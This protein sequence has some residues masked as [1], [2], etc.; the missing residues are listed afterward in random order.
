M[1]LPRDFL[2]VTAPFLK[3]KSICSILED[4]PSLCS[5]LSRCFPRSSQSASH[6]ELFQMTHPLLGLLVH[7]LSPIPTPVSKSC[8]KPH[9]LLKHS[10]CL[11]L[12]NSHLA[13]WFLHFIVSKTKFSSD[14]TLASPN[15]INIA[16]SQ[17]L[18]LGIAQQIL[19]R[20]RAWC[21][22]Y[23]SGYLA[24][25]HGLYIPTACFYTVSQIINALK[26]NTNSYICNMT[27]KKEVFNSLNWGCARLL[28]A[29][30]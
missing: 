15:L 16:P 3:M 8:S 21:L 23:S 24:L 20:Q 11:S 18:S 2:G 27:Q 19:L 6:S 4:N 26:S 29:T 28:K 10:L 9:P 12:P 5:Q 30:I 17:H 7:G 14:M 25:F 22:C 1:L 13:F